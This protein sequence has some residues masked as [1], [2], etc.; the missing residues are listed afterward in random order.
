MPYT[1]EQNILTHLC[2]RLGLGATLAATL[3]SAAGLPDRPRQITRV[4]RA[5]PR[6][7]KLVRS[8]IVTSKP[9]ASLA[10]AAAIVPSRA[11]SA[12]AAAPAP[13]VASFPAA[14]FNLA[15]FNDA[16]E[17]I[18][19]EEAIP[20]LLIH[21]VIKVESNYNPFAVS[22]KGAL[23]LMQLMP[24][25]ARRFGVADVF[26][27]IDNMQGGAKYLH[28]LLDLYGGNYTL[29]IAAY[30]AGEA[31]VEKYGSVPPFPETRN[32]VV[33]VRRSIELSRKTQKAPVA[34][35]QP[36]PPAEP[37]PAEPPHIQEIAGA[38]G[39]VRYVTR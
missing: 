13:P 1:E 36:A 31:A 35:A 5:D 11:P 4:V 7:G 6:T 3:L 38:D 10:V 18:A 32:Y 16:V 22:P 17:R 24:E 28:Y 12:P 26:N 2:F 33:Q 34:A 20:A 23:G 29:A 21:S 39:I 27:P 25:T 15:S 30:N 14:S 8:V 9:A 19:A 37:T